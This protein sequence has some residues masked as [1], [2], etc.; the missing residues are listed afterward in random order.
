M[1][2][3]ALR[4]RDC[5]GA[6]HR[7]TGNGDIGVRVGPFDFAVGP[8]PYYYGN[9]CDRTTGATAPITT[10]TAAGPS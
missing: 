6:L 7:G 4:D 9:C 10:T 1:K 2:K 3:L 8:E 5:G